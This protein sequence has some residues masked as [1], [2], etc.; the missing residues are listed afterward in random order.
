MDQ[1][2]KVEFDGL[3]NFYDFSW[4]DN[5][6]PHH[7]VTGD[8]TKM[9]EFSEKFQRWSFSIQKFMLQIWGTFKQGFFEHEIDKKEE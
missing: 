7:L 2:R 3:P 9:D 1:V 5:N 4:T 8:A 6:A